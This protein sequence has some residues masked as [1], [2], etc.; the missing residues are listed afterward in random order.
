MIEKFEPTVDQ[1]KY[2]KEL[3][4]ESTM[5]EADIIIDG[6]GKRIDSGIKETVTALKVNDYET[7]GSCEGHLDHGLPHPWV[8][9]EMS[10]TADERK[11]MKETIDRLILAQNTHKE[12]DD[13][14]LAKRD[15][16]LSKKVLFENKL[17]DLLEEFYTQHEPKN[18]DIKLFLLKT[19]SDVRIQPTFGRGIGKKNWTEFDVQQK[20]LTELEREENLKLSREEMQAFAQ[21]LKKKFFEK[22]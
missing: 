8:D 3:R 7:T 9:V 17:S 21:F 5:K 14:D 18:L 19:H 16:F 13:A 11:Q 10:L 4:W 1:K 15:I 20:R 6:L 12:Y 22:D 2:L